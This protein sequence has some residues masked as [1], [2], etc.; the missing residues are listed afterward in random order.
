MV[1]ASFDTSSP[2]QTTDE[3]RYCFFELTGIPR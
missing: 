2:K 1:R 3:M